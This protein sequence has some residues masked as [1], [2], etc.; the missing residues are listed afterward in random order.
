M[1]A[2]WEKYDSFPCLPFLQMDTSINSLTEPKHHEI[3]YCFSFDKKCWNLGSYFSFDTKYRNFGSYFSFDTKY[4]NF[5]SYFSFDI[6][7][8]TE[9]HFAD[10]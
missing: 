3:G 9:A 2:R 8:I 7:N 6:E 5:G 1:I 4:R 10:D